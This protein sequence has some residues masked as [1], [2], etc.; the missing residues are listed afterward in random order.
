L[1]GDCI[2]PKLKADKNKFVHLRNVIAGGV[3]A[4]ASLAAG[5]EEGN[6]VGTYADIMVVLSLTKTALRTLDLLIETVY[7]S[8]LE[9]SL[10]KK[11]MLSKVA[12]W[13][14]PKDMVSTILLDPALPASEMSRLLSLSKKELMDFAYNKYSVSSSALAAHEKVSA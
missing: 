12:D 5:L 1:K 11:A 3:A 2:V 4:S 14:L 7:G 6:D 10:Q 9:R 13:D 8:E